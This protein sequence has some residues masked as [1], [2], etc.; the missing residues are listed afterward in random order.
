MVTVPDVHSTG[1]PVAFRSFPVAL[2]RLRERGLLASVPYF[3]PFAR[4]EA[5][6]QGR[7]RLENYVVVRQE[8]AAGARVRRGTTVRLALA[9]E[10]FFGPRGSPVTA[11]HHPPT[12]ALPSLLGRRYAA[13]ID[14][15]DDGFRGFWV[16]ASSVAPLLPHESRRS[17][18]AFVVARQ[19]PTAGTPVPYGGL[20]VVNG[21][22]GV[23]PSV[24]TIT[25]ELGPPDSSPGSVSAGQAAARVREA[26]AAVRASPEAGVFSSFPD[27]V[28]HVHCRIPGGGP[29]LRPIYG[30]CLT[31]VDLTDQHA[32]VIL[33]EGWDGRYFR[34]QGRAR[35]FHW[36]THTWT[37]TVSAAGRIIQTSS[38]G[39][40][41]PQSAR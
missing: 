14:A 6:D 7:G 18:D 4:D 29:R 16:R 30:R 11:S 37:F 25:I 26:L 2:A 23:K 24:S 21:Q 32:L 39:S 40:F 8:P 34:T 28:A 13:A 22:R 31:A 38:F 41:P 33:S 36:L 17:L 15:G 12:I 10:Q 5:A 9:L 27:H 19:T 1:F 20:V 3:P 35:H